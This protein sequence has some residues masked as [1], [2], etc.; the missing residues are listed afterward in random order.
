MVTGPNACAVEGLPYAS[1]ASNNVS[2][3]I[4]LRKCKRAGF[5]ESVVIQIKLTRSKDVS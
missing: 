2:R 5:W 1:L 3:M 4:P